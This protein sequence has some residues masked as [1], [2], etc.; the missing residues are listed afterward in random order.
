[1]NLTNASETLTAFEKRMTNESLRMTTIG[2]GYC[3]N[4][5]TPHDGNTHSFSKEQMG[6]GASALKGSAQGR[7]II[8]QVPNKCQ[9]DSLL[10]Q[11]DNE[12]L[13]QAQTP[14]EWEVQRLREGGVRSENHQ[15]PMT[16]D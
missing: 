1:M 4:H 9:R 12:S 5:V 3:Y 8:K 6:G 13:R 14:R 11:W 10:R 7:P 16:A 2:G 15:A